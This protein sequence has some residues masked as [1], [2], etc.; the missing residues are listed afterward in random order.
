MTRRLATEHGLLV[1]ISSGA[2]MYAAL[3][4]AKQLTPRDIVVV[5]F[6]DSGRNHLSKIF[7]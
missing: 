7:S 5:I 4:Y 2:V 3:E 1:G 6:A